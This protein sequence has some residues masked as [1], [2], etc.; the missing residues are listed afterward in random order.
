M[1]SN[2]NGGITWGSAAWDN[3]TMPVGICKLCR[4][5][6]ELQDSHLIPA[7]AF[8]SLQSRES[9]NPN[10]LIFTNTWISQKSEQVHA[11]TCCRACED[12]FNDGGEKWLLPL[13]ADLD[14]GPLYD[15]VAKAEPLCVDGDEALY[16]ASSIPGIALPKI[17]HFGMAIFWK[18]SA[19]EWGTKEREVRIDL[20]SYAEPIRQF[21]LG[22]APFPHQMCLTVCV[23][24]PSVPRLG[25]LMPVRTKQQEFHRFLFYVPGI[26]FALNVGKQ[27]PPEMLEWSTTGPQEIIFVSP[28]FAKLMGKSY[29]EA[30]STAKISHGFAKY[31]KERKG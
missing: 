22:A 8:K 10:P 6:R 4:E 1:R 18:A 21:V 11:H 20:G 7:A 31:L 19:R 17:I 28:E 2:P 9:S 13:L 25:M 3:P 14:G 5:E 29:V 26:Q 27:V 24:P 15:M 23:L 12:I 16:R 30:L